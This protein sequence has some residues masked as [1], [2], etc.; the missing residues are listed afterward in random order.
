MREAILPLKNLKNIYLEE[1]TITYF[2]LGICAIDCKFAV[3]Q[4]LFLRE[5]NIHGFFYNASNPVIMSVNLK[6]YWQLQ[7]E[8]VIKIQP[9]RWFMLNPFGFRVN[10]QFHIDTSQRG[11]PKN[12][13]VPKNRHI[14]AS[15]TFSSRMN[16]SNCLIMSSFNGFN[17]E[18]SSNN[19]TIY[20]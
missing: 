2:I 17:E 15:T 19:F 12:Y 1:L 16:G 20:Q 10:P 9:P 4:N 6:K 7:S 11:W 14:I 3:G 18:F 13:S 8:F 5:A